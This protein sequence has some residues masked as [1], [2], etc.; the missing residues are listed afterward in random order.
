M[1]MG[2]K[3]EAKTYLQSTK[4]LFLSICIGLFM[5]GFVSAGFGYDNPNLPRVEEE[6]I[7]IINITIEDTNS[8]DYWDNMDIPNATQMEDSN[9]E[10]NIKEGWLETIITRVFNA[11]FGAKTTDDLTEGSTNLYDNRSWNETYA[12]GLYGNGENASWN[13]SLANTL[14]APNTTAGIQYLLNATGIYSTYNA[15]Y[16]AYA[17]N[18]SKNYTKITFDTYNATWDESGWVTDTFVPYSGATDDVDLG[19]YNITADTY[20][21]DWYGLGNVDNSFILTN[22]AMYSGGT[23]KYTGIVG[24]TYDHTGG[25]V[26]VTG[27]DYALSEGSVIVAIGAFNEVTAPASEFRL[28]FDENTESTNILIFNRTYADFKNMSLITNGNVTADWFKG[29]FNWTTFDDWNIFN[30]SILTFNDT[31]LS[32]IYYNATSALAIVGTIDAGTLADTHHSDGSY[33]GTTFNFSEAAG[34]PALDLRINFTGIED[35]NRGVIRYKT[36]SLAGNYPIVQMWNYDSSIWEDYPPV[37]ESDT[38]ATMTQPVFDSSDHLE[39]GVAQM[40]IYKASNGNTN[41]H[42]YVDWIAIVQGFGTPSGQEVDPHSI[43]RDGTGSLTGNWDVG[44]FN[45]T[46]VNWLDADYG[47]FTT[48]W[49]N[50]IN[51]STWALNVS[52]NWTAMTFTGF[53]L[54]WDNNW[55]NTWAYNHTLATYNLWNTDWLSTYNATYAGYALNVSKNYTKITFDTYDTR[56]TA[57]GVDGA[58]NSSGWN[59]S[60]TDVILHHTGDNVGIGTDS[61]NYNLE[62]AGASHVNFIITDSGNFYLPR[63]SLKQIHDFGGALELIDDS[64]NANVLIRSYSTS[65]FNG[66]NVGIGTTSPTH[67][68]NVVGNVN[69]T[70]NLTVGGLGMGVPAGA[71]MA[72][73]SA[74]C[75]VGWIPADGT[76]GTPDLRGIFVRGAG[77]SGSYTM[78]NGTAFSA[79][80]GTFLNDMF[81]SHRHNMRKSSD[82]SDITGVASVTSNAGAGAGYGIPNTATQGTMLRVGNPQEDALSGVP[83]VGS[84]TR[85]AS[86]VLTY[87]M[88]TTEDSV[89]SNTLF[90]ESGGIISTANASHEVDVSIRSYD[91][92]WISRSDWTEVHLGSNTV[93]NNDSDVIHNLNAPLSDL[94]VK[95]LVSVDGTDATSFELDQVVTWNSATSRFYGQQIY[96]RDNNSIHIQTGAHGAIY[97]LST[98]VLSAI[99][100]NDWYYKIKI[101][102]LG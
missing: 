95:I 19:I 30:G 24:G 15:T 85:P 39:D 77:T 99:G 18:V 22:G 79:V 3:T 58:L 60:G 96:G 42:Y 35:F 13:Q 82:G 11:L 21:G 37:G 59:R 14:Y 72:F 27:N 8:S 28:R 31:K 69:I 83:R 43:H 44:N 65:Y 102:K 94:L 86:Y 71:I 34:S 47:N 62:L 66:G 38:F 100:T 20:F 101:Y 68:L 92:G 91:T 26:L 6:V 52:R 61:P 36:S 50:N 73:N 78:A 53:N 48:A 12:D 84:E 4:I 56:W 81:Q 54:T 74:S 7:T 80:F 70:G 64:N 10:L 5:L 29:K 32:S 98:G 93:K 49:I 55:V 67:D 40:R 1:K 97:L 33:D 17:L 63:A 23:D 76:L 2:K 88:K 57:G 51:I 9:Q 41:N 87:C 46:N 25:M 89:T 75:P 16:D 45:I 90:Q